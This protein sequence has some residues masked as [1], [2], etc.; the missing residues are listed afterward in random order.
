V[1]DLKKWFKKAYLPVKV[2]SLDLESESNEYREEDYIFRLSIDTRGKKRKREY[3][4]IFYGH[5]DNDIRVIDVDPKRRQLI[6]LVREP[7]RE[8]TV[9]VWNSRENKYVTKIRR[10]PD[11]YRKYLLGMDESHLFIS[12][13]EDGAKPINKVKDAHKFLK[14]RE[15]MQKEEN[16]S[17]VK[18]QGEWFFI[19]ATLEELNEIN[20]NIHKVLKKVPIENTSRNP[21]IADLLIEIDDLGKFAKGK[22]KHPEHKTLKLHGWFKILKNL[23]IRDDSRRTNFID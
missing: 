3:F 15:V 14:P 19:P 12:Q 5:P 7:E 18:R 4:H 20:S 6:L 1:Q 10:T 8:F 22:I 17:Q 23:E 2:E 9:R 16:T 11:F 21:H 13:V